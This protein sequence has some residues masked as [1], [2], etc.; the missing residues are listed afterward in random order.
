MGTVLEDDC[1]NLTNLNRRE[2][3]PQRKWI[4]SYVLDS[5]L[6]R[7]MIRQEAPVQLVIDAGAPGSYN[8]DVDS[9]S[10]PV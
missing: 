2:M 9:S 7:P 10:W 5:A 6:M 3:V 1:K 4:S 8:F